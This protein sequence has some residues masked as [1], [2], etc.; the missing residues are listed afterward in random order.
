VLVERGLVRPG[1]LPLRVAYDAPCH[2]HHAQRVTTQPL[3]I[4]AAIPG[5]ELVPLE[6]ADRCCGSA[7]LYSLVEPELSRDVLAPKLRAIAASGA[8][9]VATGNPGCL[10]QI[11]AGALLAGM[12]VEVRHPVE[13]LDLAYRQ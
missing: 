8:D 4:L 1:R 12:E 11:G 5:L 9:V 6:G 13:L 7:G 2:L 3:E 10:M